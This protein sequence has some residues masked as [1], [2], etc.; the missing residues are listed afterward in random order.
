MIHFL[1]FLYFLLNDEVSSWRKKFCREKMEKME[2]MEKIMV[3]KSK[4]LWHGRNDRQPSQRF[5][6]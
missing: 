2:K 4:K 1:H 6:S 5:F 3:S